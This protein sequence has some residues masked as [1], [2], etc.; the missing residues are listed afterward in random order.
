MNDI[1]TSSNLTRRSFIKR[2]V[3][4]AVAVSSMTIFSGL[5]RASNYNPPPPP[6]PCVVKTKDILIGDVYAWTLCWYANAKAS[7]ANNSEICGKSITPDPDT[8]IA[9][10]QF[11]VCSLHKSELTA[12]MCD[13]R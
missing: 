6:K 2:S 8:G 5:V 1:Q 3:V 4:A 13:T 10:D 9:Q 7:C 12:Q 11:V